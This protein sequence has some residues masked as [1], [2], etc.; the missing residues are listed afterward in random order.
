MHA[1]MNK[2]TRNTITFSITI[3]FCIGI[4]FF[5]LYQQ[6]FILNPALFAQEKSSISSSALEK[7]IIAL[8]YYDNESWKSEDKEIIW[9]P[10]TEKNATYILQSWLNLLDEES[11]ITKKTNIQT[12][13]LSPSKKELYISFDRPPFRQED[14]THTKHI[15]LE[16]I[17]A[18][19]RNSPLGIESVHFLVHHQPMQDDQLDFSR[20]WPVSG[21][22]ETEKHDIKTMPRNTK[23]H[24]TIML[25]PAGDAQTTGRIIEDSFERGIT[26]KCCQQFKKLIEHRWDNV[27]VIL[28]RFPGE[29]LEPLQNAA[30]AN[31]LHADLYINISFFQEP[32]QLSHVGIYHFVYHPTDFWHANTRAHTPIPYNKAHITSLEQTYQLI[33][34]TYKT[35]TAYQND[36]EFVLRPP[37]GIPFKPLIGITAPAVAFEIGLFKKQDWKHFMPLLIKNIEAYVDILS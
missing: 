11:L 6:W 37:K 35:C 26:L 32:D 3:S 14:D 29:S 1:M 7:K 5:V 17:L 23:E 36:Y 2:T 27:R 4:L 25:D 30:F 33:Q 31:R 12:T 19:L 28:S 34:Q 9:S 18:T 22:L 8:I 16:S 13:L 10:I 24:L 21:Y 20:P 15:L